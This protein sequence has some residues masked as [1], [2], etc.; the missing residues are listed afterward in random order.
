M[1]SV[2][3]TAQD[4]HETD[5]LPDNSQGAD[6]AAAD[7]VNQQNAEDTQGH[8]EPD[9]SCVSDMLPSSKIRE[10]FRRRMKT[11]QSKVHFFLSC[12]AALLQPKQ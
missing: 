4:D 2:E 1:S 12:T 9:A 7:S 11:L 6:S 8:P 5:N 3:Q 10:T